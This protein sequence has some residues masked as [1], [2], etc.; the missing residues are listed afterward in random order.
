MRPI[1]RRAARPVESN[2]SRA[3]T[4]EDVAKQATEAWQL[5]ESLRVLTVEQVLELSGMCRPKF[6]EEV[7]AG[8][9]IA[10][11]C[12]RRTFILLRDFEAYLNALPPLQLDEGAAA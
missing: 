10:R 7:R 1:D 12:G 6:Y 5:P 2:S 3:V 4:R 8:R 11:K 9:L